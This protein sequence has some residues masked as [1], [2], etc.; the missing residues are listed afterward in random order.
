[1]ACAG[2]VCAQMP[3]PDALI[4]TQTQ[5]V[6]TII[7][8]DKDMRTGNTRKIL[9]MV[10]A[11]VLPY[12]D[13]NRMTMLAVGRPWRDANPAQRE[14]LVKEFRTLLVRTYSSA[15]ELYK[16]QTIDVRPVSIQ[17]SDTEVTVK[18]VINQPGTQPVHM[19]YRMEKTPQGW[20]AF[21][22]TAEGVSLVTSYRSTFANEVARGGVDGLIKSLAEKNAKL[23]T[24]PPR[25]ARADKQ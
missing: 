12:F 9:D 7:K 13:F 16:N 3:A 5:E 19:D 10:D 20:K 21:D 4:R 1:M 22:V 23:E 8:Q 6:L 25:S 15:I 14:L 11:K 17:P 2:A 24:E 18:T